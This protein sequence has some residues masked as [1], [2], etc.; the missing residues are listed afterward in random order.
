[1]VSYVKE[2]KEQ[3]QITGVSKNLAALLT[4]EKWNIEEIDLDSKLQNFLAKKP[5]M[6]MMVY[7]FKDEG[8][9]MLLEARKEYYSSG[10]MIVADENTS[11]M[12]YMKPSIHA[13]SLLL[14]PW[15]DSEM[16]EVF[17]EFFKEF[18]KRVDKE[19]EDKNQAYVIETKEGTVRVPFNR[20][21]YFEARE[22]KIFV[23]TGNEEFGFYNT[24]DNL[25]DELPKPFV[26]CHRSYIV[27]STKIKKVMYSLNTIYLEDGFE[28]P[29][30]RSYKQALKDVEI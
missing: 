14:R 28:V 3:K 20:I 5:M 15:K 16:E 26:R 2:K 8:M 22:K 24:I 18:L 23:S 17:E 25:E 7:D 13:D 11:P 19:K 12:K 29:L 4:D 1:M 10:L 27:N 9:D 30:S 21:D 6:D